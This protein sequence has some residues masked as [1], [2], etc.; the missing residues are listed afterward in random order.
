MMLTYLRKVYVISGKELD[1]FY[2]VLIIGNQEYL[3]ALNN[4]KWKFNGK[5]Y[6]KN[7]SQ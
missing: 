3:L 2:F 6:L 4:I 5:L 7:Y 1:L